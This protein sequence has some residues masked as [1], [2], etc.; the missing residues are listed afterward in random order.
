MEREL[1][2]VRAQLARIEMASDYRHRFVA[3]H[4]QAIHARLDESR[5]SSGTWLKV[6]LALALPVGI[7]LLMWAITGNFGLAVK[8][9]KLAG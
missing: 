7:F 3:W 9:A 1:Q 8:A 5:Y 4:L 2:E 6:P